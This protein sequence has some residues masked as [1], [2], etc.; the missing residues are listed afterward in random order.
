MV[1][2]TVIAEVNED[3]SF[4]GQIYILIYFKI[5]MIDCVSFISVIHSSSV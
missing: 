5:P 2:F 1:N 4:L 3:I